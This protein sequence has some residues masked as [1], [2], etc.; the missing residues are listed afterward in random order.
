MT[1]VVSKSVKNWTPEQLRFI[2][3]LALP[4]AERLPKTQTA[5]AKDFDCAIETLSRWK[6]IPGLR[7]EVNR[8]AREFVK[9]DVPEI[10]ATIR[11]E[12]KKGS[13]P[14]INMALAMAGFEIDLA[15]AGQGPGDGE[16]ARK[17]LA[18]KISEIT[19]RFEV[20]NVVSQ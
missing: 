2:Q 3:W 10:L 20:L 18:R 13:V 5:L 12:A 1:M 11:R 9:D 17:E 7:D 16:A 8:L 19:G 4:R 14:H 6:D 15:N